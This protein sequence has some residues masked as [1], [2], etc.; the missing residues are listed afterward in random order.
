MVVL[1]TLACILLLLL[2]KRTL[3]ISS[4]IFTPPPCLIVLFPWKRRAFLLNIFHNWKLVKGTS[5]KFYPPTNAR[6]FLSEKSHQPSL[7][8]RNLKKSSYTTKVVVLPTL[9]CILLLLLLKRTLCIHSAIFDPRPPLCLICLFP[10]KRRA[11]LL[12]IFHN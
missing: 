7:M 2:L 12:N 6:P 3:C 8:A 9:A 11:F 5:D 4:A 10:W 1:T